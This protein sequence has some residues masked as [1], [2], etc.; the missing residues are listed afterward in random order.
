MKKSKIIQLESRDVQLLKLFC[1][2]GFLN[3]KEIAS[4]VF[5][6]KERYVRRR[7]R[8]LFQ[9]GYLIKRQRQEG[10][11]K[12]EVYCPNLKKVMT[13][14]DKYTLERGIIAEERKVWSRSYW[15]HENELREWALKIFQI[16]PLAEIEPDFLLLEAQGSTGRYAFQS[17]L[18]LPDFIIRLPLRPS[19]AV[20]IEKS[21]KTISRYHQRFSEIM[22]EPNRPTLYLIE[23]EIVFKAVQTG[24]DSALLSLQVRDQIPQSK[25]HLCLYKEASE[26]GF[27]KQ[28]LDDLFDQDPWSSTSHLTLGQGTG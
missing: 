11:A 20:E 21:H 28:K 25:V 23:N 3:P 14:V 4:E 1:I 10:S 18:Q 7:L 5:H 16:Y 26:P 24:L 15:R 9:G 22:S 8:D 27:L 19:V 13:V 12:S 17:F 2:F 6:T